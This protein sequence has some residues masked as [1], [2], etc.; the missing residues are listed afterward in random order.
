[1]ERTLLEQVGDSGPKGF[2]VTRVWK[3]A[4]EMLMPL[5]PSRLDQERRLEDWIENDP[6]ILGIEV[7]II[8]RQV[9]TAHGGVVDLLAV[10]EEGNLVVVELK[11]DRTPRETIAQILDYASW[12][13]G[14]T[15]RDVHTQALQYLGRRAPTS[16]LGRAFRD[17][18][19]A[20]VP[21][22]LN[23]KQRLVIVAREFDES[24]KR[25]VQYLAGV[26]AMDINTAFFGI[27]RDGE[28]EFVTADWLMD[29]EEVRERSEARTQP[30]WSGFW[31]VNVGDGPTRSWE[32]GRKYGFIAAGDGA[33][34]SE[35]LKKLEDGARVFAYQKGDGSVG[36][37]LVTQAVQMAK[38]FRVAGRELLE[39]PLEQPNLGHDSDDSEKAEY[40]VGV[41]WKR[42]FP[43]SEGKTFTGAFANQNIVCKLRHP[44]TIDFLKQQFGV[45]E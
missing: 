17:L 41:D 44:T 19:G 20:A 34:Y 36:Y 26:H 9:H 18:F 31:Y 14:L 2:S 11:R 23:A 3:V 38:D 40:V 32:D 24:S 6:A 7:L 10:D 25:I 8:G 43:P 16:D 30:P 1:V 42:T 21:E 5:R 37:G 12:A 27:F 29:E 13:H 28:H 33:K 15:P 22:K 45:T 39:L 35:P 4:G